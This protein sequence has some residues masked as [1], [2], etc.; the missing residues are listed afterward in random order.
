MGGLTQASRSTKCQ[1]EPGHLGC[2]YSGSAVTR[3]HRLLRTTHVLS[4][5]LRSGVSRHAPSK[6]PREDL[7][8]ASLQLPVLPVR[9]FVRF[10]LCP[11]LPFLWGH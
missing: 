7:V 11:N 3:C 5:G 6:G 9:P 4:R 1:I 10:C 2:V 8:Q